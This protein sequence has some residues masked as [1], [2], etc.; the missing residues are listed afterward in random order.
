MR[1]L[2]VIF[3]AW[4]QTA[5]AEAPKVVTDIAP[6][7]SLV[8][9]VMQGVGE[10]AMLMEQGGDPHDFQMRPSQA[11]AVSRADLVVWMGP[12]LAPWLD[13]V[14]ETLGEDAPSRDLLAI[15][16][17]PMRIESGEVVLGASEAMFSTAVYDGET[18][19]H[20]EGEHHD[21][22]GHDDHG[23]EDNH[24]EPAGAEPH[25]DHGHEDHADA[26]GHDHGS[27]DPHAWLDPA[28]AAQFLRV[29][30][31]DLS[32]LDPENAARYQA[33]AAAG[34][35]RL[36]ALHGRISDQLSAAHDLPL[37][38]SHD[39]YGYFLSRYDLTLAGSLRDSHDSPPSAARLGRIASRFEGDTAGGCVFLEPGETPDLVEGL[40]LGP[41]VHIGRF[42]PTGALLEAGPGLYEALIERMASEVADCVAAAS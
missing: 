22:H 14:L 37:V 35:E 38:T 16:A 41:E 11:R 30:A 27:L 24:E 13:R 32:A 7:H 10:P 2:V 40:G 6:V 31:A 8:A 42:D 29:I 9:M 23:H 36:A 20:R 15:E 19:V 18:V 39:A 12:G 28:N 25:A 33:N 5:L 3:L 4:G 21:E 26:H 17:L 34:I 1:G